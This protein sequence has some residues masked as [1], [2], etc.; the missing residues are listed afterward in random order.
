MLTVKP[1][2]RQA[3]DFIACVWHTLHFHSAQCTNKQ[4][5]SLRVFGLDGV[6]D[7][8]CREDVTSR[9]AATYDNSKFIFKFFKI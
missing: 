1:T 6:G 9:S 8:Y 7:R 4:N 3:L 5:L 2:D